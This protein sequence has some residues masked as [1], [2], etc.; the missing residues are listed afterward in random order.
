VPLTKDA[1]LFAQACELGTYL[2]WLHTYGERFTPE[3][4]PRLPRG[5]AK[6]QEGVPIEPEN[7]PEKFSYD[8]E[9]Q[10]LFVGTG[11]F[12]PVA[13]AVYDFEVSGL[14]VVAS[15]LGYRMRVGSGKKSSPLDAIRPEAWTPDMTRELLELLWMLEA[16]LEVYPKQA[17]LLEEIGSSELLTADELPDVPASARK[18]PNGVRVRKNTSQE[19]DFE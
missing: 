19:I 9:K 4:N 2:L 10:T 16:T 3:G 12:H 6:V 8:A 15:W 17:A 5:S 11:S 18:A 7:Y 1:D 13:P 14:K